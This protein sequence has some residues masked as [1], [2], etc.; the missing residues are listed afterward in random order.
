LILALVGHRAPADHD[1]DFDFVSDPRTTMN[2]IEVHMAAAHFPIALMV[3]SV[4]FDAAGLALRREPL[5]ET[6][7]WVHL[8]AAVACVGTVALGL[9][10]N[11]FRGAEGPLADRVLRHQ[12]IGIATM[13]ICVALAVWRVRRRNNFSGPHLAVFAAISLAGAAVV[14]VTGYLGAHIGG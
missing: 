7:F 3:S 8:L 12:L 2:L 13:V 14:T 1:F 9:L 10:G 6:A 11:P 5:R 4:L